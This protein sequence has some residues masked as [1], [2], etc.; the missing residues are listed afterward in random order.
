MFR[1]G[2]SN[3]TPQIRFIRYQHRCW[4]VRR[5]KHEKEEAIKARD[6]TRLTHKCD[7]ECEK[8]RA[9]GLARWDKVTLSHLKKFN[10]AED[11]PKQL[12][13]LWVELHRTQGSAELEQWVDELLYLDHGIN[14]PKKLLE[15]L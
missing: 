6:D 2:G 11:L 4:H 9:C 15:T 14:L 13:P 7:L 1:S 10:L 12:Q 8:L 3:R 5:A